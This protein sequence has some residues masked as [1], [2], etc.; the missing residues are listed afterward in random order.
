VMS[1]SGIEV[2]GSEFVTPGT[3]QEAVKQINIITSVVP[4]TILDNVR[5]SN[6]AFVIYGPGE[7]SFNIPEYRH[8]FLRDNWNMAEG[9]GG[10]LS[11][12]S[13]ASV[14]RHH[15][16]PQAR[17]PYPASYISN[18]RNG[19]V[20]A[21]EVGHSVHRPGMS[22]EMDRELQAIYAHVMALPENPAQPNGRLKY[23]SNVAG[24]KIYMGTNVNEYIA[25]AF[26]IWFDAMDESPTWRTLWG[27]INKRDE[28]RRYDPWLYNF[29]TRILPEERALSEVWGRNVINEA[30]P[31]Y[32]PEPPEPT[33]RWGSSV[34]IKSAAAINPAGS[35]L[36]SYIPFN[37]AANTVP[38]VELWWDYDTCLM[39]W[40][41][42]PDSTE[43]Y[44]RIVRKNR[45]DF[46]L[47]SQRNNLVLKPAETEVTAGSKIVLA[48][49]NSE[50]ESQWWKFNLQE[51]GTFIITNRLNENFAITTENNNIASGNGIVLG[52]ADSATTRFW[53]LE[54]ASR[55]LPIMPDYVPEPPTIDDVLDI[56]M[57]LAGLPNTAP[58][59]S[60]IEDALAILMFLAG[61]A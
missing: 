11:S 39:R 15:E 24:A 4:P 58:A 14:I 31:F 42:E 2:R 36:Q 16:I 57:Q 40:Y 12:S 7:H 19:S 45:A 25:T 49:R 21:H 52:E 50:D 54:G 59:N 10:G 32:P 38:E 8:L 26:S 13:A 30:A 9:Y 1:R 27:P 23:Q 43:S 53:R 34:K 55:P 56:L 29:L 5:G 22:A 41:L 46:T 33:G 18:H 37:A 17:R 48:Q 28:L 60:T 35:G 61:L 51:D 47:N 44:F 3:V 20:L 6:A